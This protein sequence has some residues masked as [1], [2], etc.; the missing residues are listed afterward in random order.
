MAYYTRPEEVYDHFLNLFN[1][2]REELGFSQI[3]GADEN[4]LTEFPVL[5]VSIGPMGRSFHG[6]HTFLVAFSA[7]FW[8]YHANYEVG[9]TQRTLED[10]ELAT[11][12]VKFVHQPKN[13]R[14]ELDGEA[15]LITGSGYIA[16][17]VPGFA[18]A[19]RKRILATRLTWQGLSEVRFQDS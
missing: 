6:T 12:V 18:I 10:M 15:K 14:L 2:H 1:A 17:E 9:H 7:T 3:V 16:Q 13:R 8:V 11:S 4:L 5:E 19:D